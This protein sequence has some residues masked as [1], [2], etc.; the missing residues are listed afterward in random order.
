MQYL[1]SIF[2]QLKKR[3]KKNIITILDIAF[4]DSQDAK[5][6]TS[7]NLIKHKDSIASLVQKWKTIDSQLTESRNEAMDNVKY[8]STLEKFIEPLYSNDPKC[9][10]DNLHALMNSVKMIHTIAR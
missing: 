3:D 8:L 9:I 6:G 4:R 1:T 5:I 10:I 2:E 7:V